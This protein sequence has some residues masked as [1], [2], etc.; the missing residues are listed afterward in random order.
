MEMNKPPESELLDMLEMFVK[1]ARDEDLSRKE[2]IQALECCIKRLEGHKDLHEASDI[3]VIAPTI[4]KKLEDM[5]DAKHAKSASDA[6]EFV[7]WDIAKQ[8]FDDS[9]KDVTI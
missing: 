4:M 8:E 2:I 7:D 1:L 9:D 6:S 5:M 3:N